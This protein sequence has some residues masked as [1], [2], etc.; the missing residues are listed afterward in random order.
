M[1]VMQRHAP[2][3][4]AAGADGGLIGHIHRLRD[5]DLLALVEDAEQRGE[6]SALGTGQHHDVL[7]P[8]S[9]PHACA[10]APRDGGA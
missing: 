10:Q 6:E 4:G 9:E 1:L 7:G 3:R 5:D 2:H 8:K